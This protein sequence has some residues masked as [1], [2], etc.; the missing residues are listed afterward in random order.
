[1]L[2]GGQSERLAAGHWFAHLEENAVAV[3]KTFRFSEDL[4]AF[5]GNG[6]EEHAGFLVFKGHFEGIAVVFIPRHVGDLESSGD[7]RPDLHRGIAEPVEHLHLNVPDRAVSGML[8]HVELTVVQDRSHFVD[9]ILTTVFGDKFRPDRVG[10]T[11]D[12]AVVLPAV[13][14]TAGPDQAD[15]AAFVVPDP[16]FRKGPVAGVRLTG[17]VCFIVNP[18]GFTI[19]LIVAKT[20]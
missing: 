3:L 1:M 7:I 12:E 2:R 10:P 16:G 19:D 6:G 5:G 8:I 9:R 20:F 14:N 11:P 17:S 15:R 18:A 4:A 13:G